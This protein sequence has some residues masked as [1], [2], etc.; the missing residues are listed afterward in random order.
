MSVLKKLVIRGAFWTVAGYGLGQI[1]RFGSNL[2]LTRLLFPEF[3]GLMA[4]V[5][6]FIV[7][8]NLFSDVGVGLSI[9]QNK[10]GDEPDFVNTAWT[11]KVIRGLGLWTACLLFSYPMAVLYNQPQL[12]WIIPV[13]GLT[14][15]LDGF[16]STATYTLER[17]MAVRQLTVLE[18]T[19]QAIQ[20]A[21]MVVW[22]YH[23]PT[24]WALVSG[25]LVVSIVRLVWSY[26]L[27]PGLRN[28]FC[29]EKSAVQEIFSLGRWI[30]VS[31][32]LT[33]M[34][35]QAD[36][37][38]LGKLLPLD[39]LGIYGIALM[40][41]DLPRQLTLALS[42]RI[43][44]P[45]AAKMVDLPRPELRAAILRHRKKL[46]LVLTLGMVLMIGLGDLLILA[47]YDQRYTAAAWMLPI[48]ALGIWP[49]LL[50]ATIDSAL[51]AIGRVQYTTVGNFLRLLCTVGGIWFGYH[52]IGVVG[53]IVAVALNDLF[54]YASV[55]FGLQREGMGCL[56]Q[57]LQA[58]ALLLGGLA[59]LGLGRFGLG[60]QFSTWDSLLAAIKPSGIG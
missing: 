3:F 37:L 27:I 23:S 12:Q 36:R 58:T 45:A 39:M 19:A 8:L 46:L 18:L 59:L 7:G 40:L 22:A 15:I 4:L 5:N 25:N 38:M 51:I 53:A 6:I 14:T 60:I 55:S 30:F 13:V 31:T 50:C 52:Q 1:L 9:I 41:S 17:H 44:L 21:V 10:R 32:A 48:L 43:I 35:E 24:M 26:Q 16:S 33:F 11:L 28:Q 42:M 56:R 47:L 57:D 49:R 2:L 20:T 54:Y 29:W 34:A